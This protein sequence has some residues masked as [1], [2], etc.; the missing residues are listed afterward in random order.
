MIAEVH[1]LALRAKVSRQVSLAAYGLLFL[2]FLVQSAVEG[3][4]WIIWAARLVPLLMFARGIISGRLRSQ[5]WLCFVCLLYFLALVQSYFAFPESFWPTAQLALVST[6][7]MSGTLYVRWQ[8]R[9]SRALHTGDE[10]QMLE[11]HAET[12]SDE[13]RDHER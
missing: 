4:I 2:S 12:E 13:V 8:G 9:L 7:F 5:I 3:D 1:A 11:S 6:L 10:A